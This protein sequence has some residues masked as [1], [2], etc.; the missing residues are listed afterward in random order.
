MDEKLKGDLAENHCALLEVIGTMRV[1]KCMKLWAV[2]THGTSTSVTECVYSGSVWKEVW[3]QIRCIYDLKTPALPK[4]TS[5]IKAKLLPILKTFAAN[6]TRSLV[7]VTLMPENIG[8]YQV[9]GK[10]TPYNIPKTPERSENTDYSIGDFIDICYEIS[11]LIEEGY[12]FLRVEAS[13]ILAFVATNSD[14]V[15]QSGI[16]P[17]LPVAYGMRGHS[18]SM[19]TM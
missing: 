16:P 9:H 5:D 13:E 7:E 4:S 14:R 12:N 10:F 6:N 18:L 11:E 2:S 17:H 19:K 15:I 8:T 3:N 1:V